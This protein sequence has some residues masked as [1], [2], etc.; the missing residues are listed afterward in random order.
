MEADKI[1]IGET[2]RCTS[3]LLKG[4]FMAKVE[5]MYDLSALVEVDSFE[6]NDAD[7][8]EDLNGRLVVPFYCIDK[9]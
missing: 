3:P 4:N 2:Y 5:K 6:V 7:K 9:I 8:V 1:M